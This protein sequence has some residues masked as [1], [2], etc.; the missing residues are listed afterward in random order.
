MIRQWS[1]LL[2]VLALME[3]RSRSSRAAQ[4]DAKRKPN[5]IVILA[6]DLGYGDLGVQGCK[7]IKTPNID[8]LAKNGVRCTNGYVSCPVCARHAPG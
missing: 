3:T 6:D 5:V 2:A 4:P 8:S 7:D 1:I